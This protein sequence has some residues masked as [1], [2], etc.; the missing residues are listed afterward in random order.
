[1]LETD[2][3][4]TNNGVLYTPCDLMKEPEKDLEYNLVG[5]NRHRLLIASTPM[6]SN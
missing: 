3:Q 6:N 2:R 4:W 5:N 1:M